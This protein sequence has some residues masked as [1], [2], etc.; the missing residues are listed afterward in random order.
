[1][2]EPAPPNAHP[3]VERLAATH[4]GAVTTLLSEAFFDYPVMRYVL[5]DAPDYAGRLVRLIGLFTAGRWLR[6]H[7]VLGLRGADG[8]LQAA[9]T[10]TPRGAFPAPA[11][12]AELAEATWSALGADAKQRYATLCEAWS[13]TEPAGEHW[14]VN[15]L[16]VATAA[17]GAGHGGRLL[18]AALD[19]AAEDPA[20]QAVDLTTEDAAN[21]G[22][23]TRRGFELAGHCR[24]G[25]ALETWTLVAPRHAGGGFGTLR[26]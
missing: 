14:H 20:A 23:Y 13:A 22:F 2:H 10:M 15:M 19:L 4:A 9:I 11:A 12:L 3:P 26:P 25:T 17:H 6:G 7:P 16:G 8:A 1:M 24:V 18:A 21:L 5:G